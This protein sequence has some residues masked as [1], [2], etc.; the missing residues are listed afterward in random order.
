MN[1]TVSSPGF[2]IF[3]FWLASF[4]TI[5]PYVIYPLV[6]KLLATFF[7]RDK[8]GASAKE[9]STDDYCPSVTL[10]VSAFNEAP[11]IQS[12]MENSAAIEYCSD[13]FDVVVASDASDDGTDELVKAFSEK[14]PRIKLVRVEER[15]GKTDALNKVMKSV[16]TDI[17]VFSDANAMYKPDAI[18][19]LVQAFTDEGVGYAVGAARYYDDEA[20]ATDASKNETSYWDLELWIKQQE[21]DFDSVVGGDGAIY[22][23][24]TP[25]YEQMD[26]ADVSDFVNPI[27][28]VAKGHRG[29]FVPEAECYESAGDTFAEEYGRKRRIVNQSWRAVVKHRK[30][31]GFKRNLRF[32]F[33]LVSHKVIRWHS[34]LFIILAALANLYIVARTGSAFYILTLLAILGSMGAAAVAH[35][36]SKQGKTVPRLL[37]APYYFYLAA[38][39]ALAGIIQNFTGERYAMWDHIRE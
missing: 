27:Q 29:V 36:L 1:D 14:N 6:V 37:S 24:R 18:Q 9:T 12:K 19:H 38:V 15:S 22:A 2:A 31:L 13:E 7:P 28:I 34:L 39:A 20:A 4:L 35:F 30:L 25:L 33:M 32:V 11:V 10:I 3:I 23:I 26:P 21:S 17:T 16:Q 5:Y 8:E